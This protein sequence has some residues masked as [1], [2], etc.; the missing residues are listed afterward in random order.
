MSAEL[1]KNISVSKNRNTVSVTSADTSMT[2]REYERRVVH[3]DD[4]NAVDACV[5]VI[6]K[7]LFYGM[8]RFLPSC[9][10]IA[11]EAYLRANETC[12]GKSSDAGGECDEKSMNEWVDAFTGF[13]MD[14][15][16]DL[17]KYVVTYDYSPV[18]A[19]PRLDDRGH[20]RGISYCYGKP[21][22]VSYSFAK[23]I[24]GYGNGF[25]MRKIS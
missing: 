17:G 19:R 4:R 13:V 6:G 24:A 15:R 12:S 10:C 3:C 25:G 22:I 8:A 2:P 20:I 14:G 23:E 21:K 9:D 16:R 1:I 7:S 11:H 5:R 18:T